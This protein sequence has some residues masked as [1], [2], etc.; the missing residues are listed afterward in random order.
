LPVFVE[1]PILHQYHVAHAVRFQELRSWVGSHRVLVISALNASL[2]LFLTC[3]LALLI[4][5]SARRKLTRR[6]RWR[7]PGRATS[8]LPALRPPVRPPWNKPAPAKKHVAR[9]A[10]PSPSVEA[11]ARL[12]H[13]DYPVEVRERSTS[14]RAQGAASVE[15]SPEL[16]P[17]RSDEPETLEREPE[18]GI[19]PEGMPAEGETAPGV[20]ETAR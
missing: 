19:T 5:V 7:P 14:R 8:S 18:A 2:F 11:P 3:L 20:Q 4:E 6:W 10:R 13:R 15:P 12:G 17:Y 16:P 1:S 9:R